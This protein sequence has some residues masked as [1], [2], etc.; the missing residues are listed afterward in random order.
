MVQDAKS[1]V[2]NLVRQRCAEAF[3]S[4][5]K[6]LNTT[7]ILGYSRDSSKFPETIY[8]SQIF[9]TYGTDSSYSRNSSRITGRPTSPFQYHWPQPPVQWVTGK[10]GQSLKRNLQLYTAPRSTMRIIVL[11]YSDVVLWQGNYG[12][13]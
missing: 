7:K 3:N 5:V 4:G 12:L 8:I 6:G 10:D 9:F 2:K 1:P 13:S 11:S